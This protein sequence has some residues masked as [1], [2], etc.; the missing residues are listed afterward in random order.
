MSSKWNQNERHWDQMNCT[1]SPPGALEEHPG[2]SRPA[3]QMSSPGTARLDP[4]YHSLQSSSLLTASR[5]SSSLTSHEKKNQH[6][7]KPQ[8]HAQWISGFNTCFRVTV[9]RLSVCRTEVTA[10]DFYLRGCWRA[11]GGARLLPFSS[12][13]H[14]RS[15]RQHHVTETTVKRHRATR[16]LSG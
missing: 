10:A 15:A 14:Q 12:G 1:H 6:G 11:T 4:H 16:L 3:L 7:K 8:L 13:L 5:Y 2:L 9:V